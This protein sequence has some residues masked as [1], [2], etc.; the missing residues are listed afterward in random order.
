[1]NKKVVFTVIGTVMLA[2]CNLQAQATL[3][4]MVTLKQS[5]FN[6]GVKAGFNSSMFLQMRSPST[7]KN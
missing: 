1:M 3:T 6:V 2:A 5:R 4:P 7:A